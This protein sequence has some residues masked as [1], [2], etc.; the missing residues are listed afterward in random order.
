MSKLYFLGGTPRSGKT[1]VALQFLKAK[2]MFSTSTDAL[3]EVIRASM[4]DKSREKLKKIDK[5][6]FEDKQYS[7]LRKE[8]ARIAQMQDEESEIVW[9]LIQPYIKHDY[10]NNGLDLLIEGIAVTPKSLSSL[11]LA[12]NAVFVGNQ[13]DRHVKTI[14]KHAKTNKDDWMY[15]FRLSEEEIT[16]FA[17]FSQH[18]S[19]HI[20]NQAREYD[21]PYIEMDDENFEDSVDRV[22]LALD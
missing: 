22:L 1:R 13:S 14:I 16:D 10:I 21:Y 5:L 12:F 6:L 9:E 19:R 11:N 18:Y 3:R 2:P 15:R 20:Q 4:D 17:I 8:P 7:L